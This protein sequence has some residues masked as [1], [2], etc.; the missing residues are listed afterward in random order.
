MLLSLGLSRM[1]PC[2]ANRDEGPSRNSFNVLR[3]YTG[4][5]A[6]QSGYVQDDTLGYGGETLEVCLLEKW[7]ESSATQLDDEEKLRRTNRL[8]KEV[9]RRDYLEICLSPD[10]RRHS[11]PLYLAPVQIVLQRSD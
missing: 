11:L 6:S 3:R 5:S 2:E 1:M 8:K 4:F 7:R 10:Q 9:T